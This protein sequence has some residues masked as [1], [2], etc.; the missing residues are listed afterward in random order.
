[1][2]VTE[3]FR[4]SLWTPSANRQCHRG[5]KTERCSFTCHTLYDSAVGNISSRDAAGPKFSALGP[6]LARV[7]CSCGRLL[8]LMQQQR[9]RFRPKEDLRGAD[10]RAWKE[11]RR[12]EEVSLCL[13][14]KIRWP[15]VCRRHARGETEARYEEPGSSSMRAGSTL[16]PI[17]TSR[18]QRDGV[19]MML[20]VCPLCSI[21]SE[22]LRQTSRTRDGVRPWLWGLTTDTAWPLHVDELGT[23]RCPPT[24]FLVSAMLFAA[25]THTL[26]ML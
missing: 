7:M 13:A 4:V 25:S 12:R 24:S 20:S 6:A 19:P 18:A 1:M 10:N 26:E 17:E 15:G 2:G 16:E 3:R 22:M 8:S 11:K 9:L 21:L 5:C 14:G 23:E